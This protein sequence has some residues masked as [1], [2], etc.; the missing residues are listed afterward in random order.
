MAPISLPCALGTGCDYKTPE[1]EYDQADAQ[2]ERHMKYAHPPT[3]GDE[4]TTGG[5]IG[6]AAAN[7]GDNA[8]RTESGLSCYPNG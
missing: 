7:S 1:L 8:Q 5:A 4:A 3:A 6:G 2:L